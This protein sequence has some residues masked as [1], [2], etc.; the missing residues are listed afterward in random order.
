MRNKSGSECSSRRLPRLGEG[1]FWENSAPFPC[2]IA[3]KVSPPSLSG[4]KFDRGLLRIQPWRALRAH[5]NRAALGSRTATTGLAGV[6]TLPESR[7]RE[8]P[9]PRGCHRGEVA[10]SGTST[11]VERVTVADLSGER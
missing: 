1:W 4:A 11:V 3:G 10:V 8:R 2:Q 9:A 6:S 5:A 7:R